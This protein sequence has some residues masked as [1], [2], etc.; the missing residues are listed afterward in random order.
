LHYGNAKK[1]HRATGMTADGGFAEY[2]LH[3]L[4]G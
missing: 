4:L 2:V 3:H 1:G